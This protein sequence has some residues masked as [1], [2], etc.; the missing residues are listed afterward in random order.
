M[1]GGKSH[2]DYQVVMNVYPGIINLGNIS[3][4][5]WTAIDKHG[6]YMFGVS[7]RWTPGLGIK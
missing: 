3:P 5:V 7:T 4:G 1:L 6:K 2:V